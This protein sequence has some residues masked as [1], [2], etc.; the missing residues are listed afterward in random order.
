MTC[1]DCIHYDVCQYHI[2]EETC[3]TVEECS[4][5]N[6]KANFVEIPCRCSECKKAM[7][8]TEK[9]NGK[10]KYLCDRHKSF[11]LADSFCSDGERKDT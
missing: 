3:M 5:F 1:K 2:D 10:D 7:E 8:M 4:H 9:W 6:N 11:V